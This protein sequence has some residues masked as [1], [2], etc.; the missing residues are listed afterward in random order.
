MTGARR[1][2]FWLA[3]VLALVLALA[4]GAQ[5]QTRRAFLVGMERYADGNIQRLSRAISDARDLASDLEQVG[6]DKK[7]IKVVADLRSKKDFQK[8]FDA[9]LKTVQEGDVVL[10]YYSGHGFGVELDRKNYIL[11]GDLRSPVAFTRA[12]LP[13]EERRNADVVRLR[14][15]G[16]IDAYQNEE[17]PRSGLS[18]QEIQSQIAARKPRSAIV[19]LDACRS[20]LVGDPAS[21][22]QRLK[23][24]ADSGSRLIA[25]VEPPPGFV[26][27]YSASFGE[28]AVESFGAWDKRRNSLFTEILRTELLRPGQTL[29]QLAARTRL[30][31]RTIADAEGQQQEPDFVQNLKGVDD[32][33]FVEPVGAERFPFREEK[34]QGAKADWDQI[35]RQRRRDFFE[36]HRRRFDGCETAELA[37]RALVSFGD[38]AVDA[39]PPPASVADRRIDDCDRLA[40]AEHDRARPP[41]VPGIALDKVEADDAIAACTK[42]V[43]ANPRIIRFLFNLGRAHFKRGGELGP[44]DAEQVVH[45]RRARLAFE[46]A[47]KRGYLAALNNL[48]IIYDAG[49]GVGADEKRADELW[50]S[51]AQQGHPLAMY[52][53]A[54]RYQSGKGGIQR[55]HAQ[56][57]EWFVKAAES[58]FV[59]AMV[60]TG[61]A[62]VSGRGLNARNPRRAV[63][64]FERAAA[65]GSNL[66]RVKLGNL[67]ESGRL[68]NTSS[69]LSPTSV[70]PD[71]S[72]A[73]IWYGRAAEAGDS[74]AQYALAGIM[75]GGQG[76]PNRQP[77]IGER[78]WRLAAYGG[79]LEAEVE[80]AEKLRT[81]AMLVKPENGA[82]E[83]IDL[84]RRAM[85]LGSTR[86]ALELAKIYRKGD[87]DQARN[88]VEAMKLAYHAIRLSTE[89]DPTTADG[90][91]F[92][93]IA[94]GH[95]LAEMAK[96]GEAVD[97]ATGRPLLSKDETDRLEYHYGQVDAASAQ[98]KVRRLVVPISCSSFTR[99]HYLWVWDWGRAESPTEQQIRTIERVSGCQ[100]NQ[101]LRETLVASFQ[102]AKKNKIAFADLIEQQIKTA[103]AS[104]EAEATRRRR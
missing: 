104:T 18:E 30:M 3:S 48:A 15:P 83:G 23:R 25:G 84:L 70:D 102:L 91:P 14:M 4:T 53:L 38:T 78:Y 72:L 7:N 45:F 92:H 67:Y 68:V 81:G 65:A 82:Q 17:I 26:V 76:L 66:A 99:N 54:L 20:L 32:F 55:D 103:K 94:A 62:L 40:A 61:D 96:A 69:G 79:V 86:A 71:P 50:K 2:G 93:E 80:L 58:G 34:C 29:T 42:S 21:N 57:Y 37:R 56:A 47:Q 28:T 52:N 5:A 64:W 24:G 44:D 6:F 8:E 22:T 10:F 9:F 75:E 98:V 1:F 63:E 13:D 59:P 41:E 33:Y 35:V 85:S 77:E 60:E 19:V 11:F 73:L 43:E 49:D 74:S 88:P 101:P 16:F 90:N 89:A 39:A 97:P 36:R 46:D 51:A 100:N 12:Q 31:V 95:L 87:F 27:L